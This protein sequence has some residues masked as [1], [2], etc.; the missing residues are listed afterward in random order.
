MLGGGPSGLKVNA[1]QGK[2]GFQLL[3]LW[4][5]GGGGGGGGASTFTMVLDEA[6]SAGLRSSLTLQVTVIR[7]GCAPRVFNAAVS[8]LP[9]I[10]PALAV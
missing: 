10:S 4:R 3:D 9:E 1:M 2:L 7:P 8:P 6:V 5:W